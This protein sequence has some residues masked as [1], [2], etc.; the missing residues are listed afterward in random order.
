M[1][2]KN[3]SNSEY[4]KDEDR[5]ERQELEKYNKKVTGAS[6]TRYF[7]VFRVGKKIKNLN[8]IEMFEKHM[9][10][11]MNVFNADP[12]HRDKNRI[13]IGDKNVHEN[14]KRY[15]YGIKIRSNANLGVDL[16]LSAGNG[17]Y[18]NLP[19]EEQEIW[20]QENIKFL[21]ENFGD[22]C[23]YACLHMDET[24]PHLHILIIPK[25][26]NEEKKRY[27]LSSNKYFDGI[28]KMR[29]WQDKYADHMNSKFNNL[30]RGIRG[31]KARHTDI[32]TY[33]NLITKRLDVINGN[34]IEAYAK[35]NF[36]LEKRLKALEYTL[37]RMNENGDT[38]KL[39]RKVNKLEKNNKI[40]KDTIKEISKKYGIEEKEI[41]EL[42]DK[43]QG[44]NNKSEREK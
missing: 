34:Q 43:V 26:W 21:K 32:K 33:Y 10:R 41:L 42:V 17:F 40:Y 4:I 31:S 5:N 30:I 7:C 29:D 12:T 44:K 19:K 22:N 11:E 8:Q 6:P 18:Y 15:I 1:Q 23:I 14:V 13:L 37:A 27:E 36:L 28:E 9:N 2:E 16:V 39:L 20:V 24:T 35:R 38:D 25:F 3:Y